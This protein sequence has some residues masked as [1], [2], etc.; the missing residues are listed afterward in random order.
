MPVFPKPTIPFEFDVKQEIAATSTERAQA[1]RSLALAGLA[2]YIEVIVAGNEVENGKPAPDI[3]LRAAA[4]I[5]V[6]PTACVALEDSAVGV[7]AAAAA[8]M[9]TIMVPDLHQPTQEVAAL[10]NYVLPS[11]RDAARVVLRMFEAQGGH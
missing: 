6:A 10:A 7:R 5:G 11:T 9:L 3:F 4:A 2:H 1:E 8:Q